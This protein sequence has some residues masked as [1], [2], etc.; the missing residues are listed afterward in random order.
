MPAP[1]TPALAFVHCCDTLL[2][3][4]KP[5]GLPAVPGRGAHLQDCVASRV[6]AE[7]ADALVVHRL[8]MATSGLMLMAR[9]AEAQRALGT[10]FA[11][12][13]VDKRYVAIVC[14]LLPSPGGDGWGVI[15]L[16]LA[17]D[18]PERPRQKVDFQRGKAS[19]TRYRVLGHEPCTGCSRVELQPLTGRTHQLRLHLLALGHPIVGDTLYAPPQVQAQSARL[20]LHASA[21]TL[22]H[23]TAGG[24]LAFRSAPPF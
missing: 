16:P 17:A 6:Q 5:S 8:D 4:D 21:L 23:P 14:G 9:G 22:P 20:L 2:V 12:R 15:D 13:E 19:L 11:R 7:F 18:W 3:I 24:Q 10:A 1:T